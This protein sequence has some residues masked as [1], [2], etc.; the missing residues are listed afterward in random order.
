MLSATPVNNKMTDIKNQIAFI[1]ED[2]DSALESA[3][4]KSIETTLKNA[5]MAF[6]RWSKLPENER[7]GASFVDAVDLDY[8]QLLDTLTIARS[9][10]H[11]EKYYDLGEIGDF[12]ERLTPVNV[13]SEIDT[14]EMF[15]SLEIINKTISSIEMAIYSP[16]RYIRLDKKHEYESTLFL[17]TTRTKSTTRNIQFKFN[18]NTFDYFSKQLSFNNNIHKY[19]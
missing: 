4:I 1:T 15:P 12:P 6:N 18:I 3:G 5:Q 2:N 7:T 11:I 10:K 19:N 13:K 17:S 9:R 14:E 8:F 16:M